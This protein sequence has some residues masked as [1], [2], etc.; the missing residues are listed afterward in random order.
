M[1]KKA[2]TGGQR[3][4]GAWVKEGTESRMGEHDQV[5]VD[6]EERGLEA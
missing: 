4:R 1:E 3:E 2:V 6:W 5:L